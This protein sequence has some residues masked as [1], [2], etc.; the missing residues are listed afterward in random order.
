MNKALIGIGILAG[1]ASFGY[2]M[3][4]RK[5][6]A[7]GVPD[8]ALFSSGRFYVVKVGLGLEGL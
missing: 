7:Q 3:G 4:I 1:V 5:L 2:V 6:R 8:A